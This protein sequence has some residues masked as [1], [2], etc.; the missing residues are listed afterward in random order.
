MDLQHNTNKIQCR[1]IKV[2]YNT[3]TLQYRAVPYHSIYYNT[4]QVIQY[5]Y[6]TIQH[7]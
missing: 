7:I 3:I 6:N 4:V 5:K 1:P 2:Q